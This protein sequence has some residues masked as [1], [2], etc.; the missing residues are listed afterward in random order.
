M[1]L[2]TFKA[3]LEIDVTEGNGKHEFFLLIHA[4]STIDARAIAERNYPSAN[5]KM[6]FQVGTMAETMFKNHFINHETI[7]LEGRKEPSFTP[8]EAGRRVDE[9]RQALQK[10][11]SSSF[12]N[13]FDAYEKDVKEMQDAIE[14]NIR[15]I[16]TY[17]SALDIMVKLGGVIDS[18]YNNVLVQV[19]VEEKP[20][21]FDKIV[22]M[23]RNL[24]N[25]IGRQ[26]YG[27]FEVLYFEMK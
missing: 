22:C 12:T 19:N 3:L 5:V 23:T 18:S 26:R 4:E 24:V 6:V 7:E 20:D 16:E 21:A 15:T 8:K 10:H 17:A 27:N 13:P 14:A 25:H 1:R 11:N 2:K 9:Y